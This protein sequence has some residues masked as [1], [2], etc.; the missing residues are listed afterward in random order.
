MASIGT[1]LFVP[2]IVLLYC[3]TCNAPFS[4]NQIIP[5]IKVHV[6]AQ[7]IKS[8]N[9]S[10]LSSRTTGRLIV[11]KK[12]NAGSDDVVRKWFPEKPFFKSLTEGREWQRCSVQC[13]WLESCFGARNCDELASNFL[14]KFPVQVSR[15]CVAGIT[16]CRTVVLQVAVDVV[17]LYT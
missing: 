6:F 13:D 14:C 3:Y 4:Q 8:V 9:Q 5:L 11:N 7:S 1:W 12:Y 10:C 2:S 15:A 16:L 17:G